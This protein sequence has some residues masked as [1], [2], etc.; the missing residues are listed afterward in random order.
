[1]RFD[2]LQAEAMKLQPEAR[3]RLAHALLSSLDDLSDPEIEELWLEESM[4]RDEATDA[5]KAE[6]RPAEDVFTN[7]PSRIP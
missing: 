5:A 3:A 7:S 4:F 6:M 2:E 1:M